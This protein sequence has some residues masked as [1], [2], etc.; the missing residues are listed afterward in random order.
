MEIISKYPIMIFKNQ[1]G[2]YYTNL[3]RKKSDGTYDKA[4]FQVVFDRDIHIE[5]KT[6]IEIKQ[7]WLDFNNWEFQ[8]KKGTVFYIRIK[9]FEELKNE[10]KNGIINEAENKD[11]Y[12]E[13]GAEHEDLDLPF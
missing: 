1:Y 8:D 7:A 2:K 9:K 10:E 4:Y 3:S 13:F 12:E 5:N 11:P 6:K